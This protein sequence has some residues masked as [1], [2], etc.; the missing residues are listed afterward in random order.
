MQTSLRSLFLSVPTIFTLACGDMPIDAADVDVVIDES[1]DAATDDELMLTS[2]QHTASGLASQVAAH[3]AFAPLSQRAYLR[4]SAMLDA[5]AMITP[6]EREQSYTRL[7]HCRL[8]SSTLCTEEVYAVGIDPVISAYEIGLGQQLN[9]A[10]N[11]DALTRTQRTV[12]L[13]DAQLAYVAAGGTPPPLALVPSSFEGDTVACNQ[14]C[15]TKILKGMDDAAAGTMARMASDDASDETA[16]HPWWVEIAIAVGTLTI[17]C[18]INP[19]CY[20]WPFETNPDN[21]PP[22][23]NDNG[24][25]ESDQYCWKGPLGI[26]ENECR[27]KKSVGDKCGNG[28]ACKSGCCKFN[29][30]D[31]GSTCRV[32]S[33]CN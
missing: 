4:V 28:D 25:C 2:G 13:R 9:N 17:G 21:P 5:S 23:C 30:W 10:F 1:A 27:D 20:L 11:L 16:A 24:D 29:L 15:K 32:A 26:G 3:P 14:S 31:G 6:E 18:L 7:E 33:E 8:V 19:D 12:L 22:E